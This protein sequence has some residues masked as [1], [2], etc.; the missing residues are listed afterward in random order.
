M[1]L[2]LLGKGYLGM[3]CP[4]GL[5]CPKC[6]KL[7]IRFHVDATISMKHG[8]CFP[9]AGDEIDAIKTQTGRLDIPWFRLA[10]GA[11]LQH[12]IPDSVPMGQR[13]R[14]LVDEIATA[15]PSDTITSMF[16][17]FVVTRLKLS[18]VRTLD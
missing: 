15:K 11:A 14:M 10:E 17:R 4:V 16:Y 6:K 18:Y 1:L 2:N 5:P 12:D 7:S 8:M 9:I 13:V 3:D